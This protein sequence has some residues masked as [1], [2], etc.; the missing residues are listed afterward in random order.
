MFSESLKNYFGVITSPAESFKN[1]FDNKLSL[2]IPLILYSIV[3][4]G[5]TH[6]IYDAALDLQITLMEYNP[7][8]DENT[9]EM[10]IQGTEMARS[11]VMRI[12]FAYVVPFLMGPILFVI[13][14]FFVMVAGNFFLGGKAKFND[15]FKLV[16][17]ASA[18]SIIGMVL[19]II[20]QFT[21]DQGI[22]QFSPAAL[23]PLSEYYTT[24]YQLLAALDLFQLLFLFFI[25]VG[26]KVLY[27]FDTTK[28]MLIPFG[29]YALYFI[30]FKIVLL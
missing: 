11:G 16:T 3:M 15:L 18:L 9:M 7:A 10:S 14:A 1:V 17:Y 22:V 25:G 26:I 21:G 13:I 19:Q 28:A 24:T 4:V 2:W 29:W 8:I 20:L 27:N 12:L 23:L 30:I 5:T 6:F